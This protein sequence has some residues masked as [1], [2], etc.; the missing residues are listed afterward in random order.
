MTSDGQAA[1][2]C[3]AGSL[4]ATST[5][6]CRPQVGTILGGQPGLSLARFPLAWM[7][8]TRRSLGPRSP[9]IMTPRSSP[10]G[11]VAPGRGCRLHLR[12]LTALLAHVSLTPRIADY[13]SLAP[14]VVPARP[15]QRIP[16]AP[17]AAA[18]CTESGVSGASTSAPG[19]PTTCPAPAAS[20]CPIPARSAANCSPP[21]CR[22][23][24]W[25]STR[26]GAASSCLRGAPRPPVRPAPSL[27]HSWGVYCGFG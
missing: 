20:R 9:K 14:L 22:A 4:T 6:S 18:G 2:Q 23:W 5:A 3:L 26:R 12:V 17:D 25:H 15:A 21:L 13:R 27:L 7:G 24:R 8:T 11:P 10:W 1:P 19:P 16:D